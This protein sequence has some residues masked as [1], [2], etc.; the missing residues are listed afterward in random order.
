MHHNF[1]QYEWNNDALR[2]EYLIVASARGFP[3]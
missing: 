2:H 1:N 3:N